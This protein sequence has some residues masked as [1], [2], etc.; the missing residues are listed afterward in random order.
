MDTPLFE[1][2]RTP[3]YARFVGP[4]LESKDVAKRVVGLLDR[5]EGGTLRLPAYAWC[6]NAYGVLPGAL[7]RCVRWIGGIDAAVGKREGGKEE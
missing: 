4:V 3:W 6:L 7:Q 5:G 1:G 2:V